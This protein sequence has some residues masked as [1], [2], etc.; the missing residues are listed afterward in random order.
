MPTMSPIEA[1]RAKTR[2]R[3]RLSSVQAGVFAVIVD[4]HDRVLLCHRRDL[5]LWNLPGGGVEDGETP[6]DA[7]IREVHE[8]VGIDAEVI[9]LTGLYWKPGSDELVFSFECRIIRGSP[10]TSDEADEVGFFA[11]TA[12][13]PNTI[14][15][16]V[17][18]IVDALQ[19]VPV[20]FLRIQAGPSIRT[21]V[22][23]RGQ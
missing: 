13:P 7:V 9:R 2:G 16:Q 20:P 18:R 8:E 3:R 17:E 23:A 5:D 1:I 11:L 6:W 10:T 12:L 15:K 4:A 19:R 14:P 21:Q 22:Q